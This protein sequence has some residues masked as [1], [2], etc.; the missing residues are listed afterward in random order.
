LHALKAD[1]YFIVSTAGATDHAA[2]AT[3]YDHGLPA[4]IAEAENGSDLFRCLR[5]Q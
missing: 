1:A 2:E 5:A 4:L 3:V